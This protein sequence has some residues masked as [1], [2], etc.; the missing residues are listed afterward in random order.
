MMWED[1]RNL[2]KL[3]FPGG[4]R[5]AINEHPIECAARETYEELAQLLSNET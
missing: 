5:E 4:K 2:R 1:R 3:N